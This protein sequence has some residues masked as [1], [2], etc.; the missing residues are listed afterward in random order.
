MGV[1]VPSKIGTT[2]SLLAFVELS[3]GCSTK[4]ELVYK[5]ILKVEALAN[6][7]GHCQADRGS[8]EIR[9]VDTAGRTIGFRMY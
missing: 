5:S 7:T 4:P 3:R 9:H 8:A 1:P 2:T 6:P